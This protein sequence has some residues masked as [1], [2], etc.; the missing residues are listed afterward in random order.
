MDAALLSKLL[1]QRGLSNRAFARA[2]GV[3]ETAVRNWLQERP[4]QKL[5]AIRR[6][7]E[8]LDCPVARLLGVEE[9]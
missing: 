9:E 4:D 8:V 2:A 7:A 3:S 1:S 6:A 5:D